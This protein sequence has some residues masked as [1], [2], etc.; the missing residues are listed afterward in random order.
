MEDMLTI[1]EVNEILND[2]TDELPKEVFQE[3]HGGIS[4]WPGE[5]LNPQARHHDLYIMGEYQFS[6]NM[7]NRITIYYG[8]FQAVLGDAPKE[9]WVEQLREVLRHEFTHHLEILAGEHDLED[10]DQQQLEQYL[11]A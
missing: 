5:K 4:L 1:D 3:L 8:S 11:K 6:R 10:W 2:L 7:G 9:K